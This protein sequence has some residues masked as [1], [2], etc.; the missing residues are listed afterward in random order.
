MDR[1]T[2]GAWLGVLDDLTYYKLLGV[3]ADAGPDELKAAFHAFADTFHPDAHAGRPA[4]E[5]EAIGKIF[6]RGTEAYRVLCDPLL[7]AHYE[8]SLAEGLAPAIASRKSAQPPATNR[9]GPRRLEDAIRSPS[10][11]PF[12]RRAEE[13]AKA[14]D[15]KQAKLQ[16]SLA[17]AREPGNAAI[18]EFLKSLE[19][20][21]KGR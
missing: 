7:R 15:F 21:I 6:R 11:R 5:R 2:I 18:D 17:S 1:E 14:G 16:L 8:A 19:E 13:L 10:A 9:P 12:A 20:K 3:R 4:D